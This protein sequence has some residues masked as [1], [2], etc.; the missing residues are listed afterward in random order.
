MNGM[1]K[2]SN[3]VTAA[4]LIFVLLSGSLQASVCGKGLKPEHVCEIPFEVMYSH[5]E[6]LIGRLVS[7]TGVLVVGGTEEPPGVM[8]PRRF[9]FPSHE[10]VDFCL[11]IDAVEISPNSESID[12]ELS[13]SNG[14]FVSLVGHV[15]R[16]ESGSWVGLRLSKGPV[17]R[18]GPEKKHLCLAD[19]SLIHPPA[20]GN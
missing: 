12:Q 1:L 13:D 2:W 19:P 16:S 6:E 20:Q 15:E 7:V 5:R 10:R 3:E 14:R 17:Q 9:L 11:A 18:Q 8:T 4:V